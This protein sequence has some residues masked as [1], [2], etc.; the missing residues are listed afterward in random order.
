MSKKLKL[1][2]DKG[3]RIIAVAF[4]F[5]ALFASCS[6]SKAQSLK[7]Q[8]KNDTSYFMALS[9][10]DKGDQKS[11]ITF[12]KESR[13]KSNPKIARM[14]AIEL[15]KIGNVI[16]RTK[17]CDYICKH[18]DDAE[19]LFAACQVFFEQGEY[20]RII[21]ITDRFKYTDLTDELAELRF[22]SMIK[23]DD[24]R[25]KEDLF[26]WLICKPYG[27]TQN[28]IW[29]AFVEFKGIAAEE[30]EIQLLIFRNLVYKKNYIAACEESSKLRE[31]YSVLDRPPD[32]QIISDL[33]K[34]RLYGT[35]DFKADASK[36][37]TL[38]RTLDGQNAYCAYFYAARLYDRAGRYQDLTQSN[39]K[40]ALDVI[41]D[42]DQFD[43]CLWYLL[44]MQLRTSTGDIIQTLKKYANR[45]SNQSYFDDFF[46]NLSVLL[47]SHAQWQD[48]YDVWKIIDNCA[49]EETACKFAYL[50]GRILEEGYGDTRGQPKTKEAVAA[51]TRV[52]SGNCDIYYKVCA[53]ERMNIVDKTYVTDILLSGGTSVD[54]ETDNDACTLLS[55]YAAFGFPQK[56]YSQWLSDR[57]V[58]NLESCIQASKFLNQCGAFSNDYRV[59]SLRIANRTR[60]SWAGKIPY[61]LLE[62]TYPRFYYQFIEDACRANNLQEQILYALIR[63]ESFFDASISSKAGAQGLTQ[64]MKGTADD[65]A[66]KL[67]LG[68]DYD[69][70]DPK[71]NIAM[72]SHYLASLI[73]RTPDNSVLLAMLA[74][75]AGLTNVRKW[76]NANSLPMD[77]YVE[78]LPFPETRGYGRKMVGAAAM[79]GFLYYGITPAQTVREL[80]YL[81]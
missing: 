56:I 77:F 58:L 80:L 35:E 17:A 25:L 13:A 40:K 70:L 8:Y 15:S 41:E 43:N 23:K 60:N 48:F 37:E 24:S 29:N 59:Q 16:E 39:F 76:K 64:L 11:A 21:S 28:K 19:A 10:L 46:D 50:S 79:Y 66:R 31:L 74:Y 7:K 78:T 22:L 47:L 49:S 30:P 5:A 14:S 45:I 33:G 57:K 9:A 36:F 38:A 62:L 68:D 75:N 12:F 54:N 44:N 20:S 71:T 73:G 4:L 67:K 3:H 34:A 32:Y 53:L 6:K 26:N 52:L 69:I 51:F 61:E 2:N 27:K 72:G 18:Y 81:K 55:G 1:Y 65:E 42:G 63:S